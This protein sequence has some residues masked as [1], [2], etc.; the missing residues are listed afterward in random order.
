MG[1]FSSLFSGSS[2]P[3]K[4][5]YHKYM[6]K[7]VNS[8]SVIRSTDTDV[9]LVTSGMNY[10]EVSYVAMYKDSEGCVK[11]ISS[12]WRRGVDVPMIVTVA[13]EY[14]IKGVTFDSAESAVRALFD[15]WQ[16]DKYGHQRLYLKH[17]GVLVAELS[18]EDVVGDFVGDG[19]FR[20]VPGPNLELFLARSSDLV[21]YKISV[22]GAFYASMDPPVVKNHGLRYSVKFVTFFGVSVEVF[23]RSS[24]SYEKYVGGDFTFSHDQAFEILVPTTCNV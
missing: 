22:D 18:R 20:C 16:M 4:R 8:Y 2:V 10:S 7:L 14:K 9:L 23:G 11:Y 21:F 17:E 24:I 3:D 13:G 6:S 5:W 1:L 19:Y 12:P 15:L